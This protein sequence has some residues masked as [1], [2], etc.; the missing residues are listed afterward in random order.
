MRGVRG[1]EV[2]LKAFMELRMTRD[3]TGIES[4]IFCYGVQGVFDRN[5]KL[6]SEQWVLYFGQACKPWVASVVR[7]Q[8]HVSLG[9]R[10]K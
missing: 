7:D 6:L 2:C 8:E 1:E 5:L 9:Q 3:E 10:L 4:N